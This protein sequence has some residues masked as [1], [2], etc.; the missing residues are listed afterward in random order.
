MQL[1]D[2]YNHCLKEIGLAHASAAAEELEETS[3]QENLRHSRE[4]AKERG[5]H[6]SQKVQAERN[7]A[8]LTKSLPNHRK[9]LVRDVENT[10][11]SMVAKI[12]KNRTPIK[13][14]KQK[15]DNKDS[16]REICD[17]DSELLVCLDLDSS[18]DYEDSSP[19]KC[20]QPVSP[21]SSPPV[22]LSDIS[23]MVNS[24]RKRKISS[25]LK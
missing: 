21:D 15:V 4:V 10:R 22:V 13:S 12:P 20:P 25:N 7:E 16:P 17:S 18:E 23:D 11:A 14:F 2:Q 19:A 9:T 1:Q 5:I 24:P 6:A 8:N 3:K